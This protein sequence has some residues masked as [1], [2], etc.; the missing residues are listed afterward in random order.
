MSNAIEIEAK[1]LVDKEEYEKLVRLFP[2]CPR[3][4]QTNY[5]IDTDNRDL[6]KSGIALRIREKVGMLELT[7]KTPLSQGKLEKSA[8]ITFNEFAA[9]RDFGQF[10]KNDLRRFLLM[11]DFDIEKLKILT[12]L[13]T[14]RLDVEYEGGKISIDK[15]VYSGKTDYEVE[16]EFNNIV[17]AEEKLHAFLEEHG[18]AYQPTK[19]SKVQRAMKAC[20]K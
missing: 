5:Y 4:L 3:Y 7:L 6:A 2:Q 17:A 18:V 13:S 12:S 14:E 9:F 8:P 1:A 19:L 20:G 15:N 10:P 16:F 11:L